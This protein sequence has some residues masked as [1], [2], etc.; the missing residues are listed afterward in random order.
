VGGEADEFSDGD[1]SNVLKIFADGLLKIK[2]RKG[3]EMSDADFEKMLRNVV[4]LAAASTSTAASPVSP[5]RPNV[6]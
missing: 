3:D 1:R 4:N 5:S 2:Q 6:V